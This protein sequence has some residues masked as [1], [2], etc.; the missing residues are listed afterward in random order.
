MKV[1]KPDPMGGHVNQGIARQR[2]EHGR[3]RT[4]TLCGPGSVFFGRCRHHGLGLAEWAV[5]NTSSP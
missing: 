2:I 4:E 1:G 5:V 3:R